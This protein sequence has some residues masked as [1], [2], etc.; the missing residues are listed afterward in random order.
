[1]LLETPAAPPAP[2]VDLPSPPKRADSFGGSS[3]LGS[4]AVCGIDLGSRRAYVRWTV[5][6]PLLTTIW[7]CIG[8]EIAYAAWI[9][10]YATHC[11][12]M[13][14]EEA[15]YL[16]SLYWS[17]FTVA[18]L[19]AT[20]LAA[21]VSP[22]AI[23][24]P[25]LA[26]EVFS[27]LSLAALPPT[28]FTLW[29]GTIGA[30]IGISVLFS[31]VLSLLARYGLLSTRVTGAM[32]AAA[33]IGHMT[34]PSLAGMSIDRLGYDSL[35][36]LLAVINSVGFVLTAMVVLHLHASFQPVGST[37]TLP[38]GSPET[39]P[40]NPFKAGTAKRSADLE[41]DGWEL[42]N[43]RNGTH[44]RHDIDREEAIAI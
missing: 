28:G 7:L 27:L 24:V 19:A 25:A 21:Y 29:V 18:R 6:A 20:P 43:G 15:A 2:P 16:T 37:S 30:G 39:I 40:L 33:A 14:S 32:G 34:I 5:L 22:G 35:L 12:S 44:R 31:N 8:A 36:P 17:S 26:L 41:G 10:T 3:A 23:L 1:M 11:A 42:Q 38:P 9:Y 13:R 4:S